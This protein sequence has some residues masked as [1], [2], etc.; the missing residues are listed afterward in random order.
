MDNPAATVLTGN[1]PDDKATG[2]CVRALAQS[3]ATTALEMKKYA[4]RRLI[5]QLLEEVNDYSLMRR[6]QPGVNVARPRAD[7]GTEQSSPVEE[8]W[9]VD[10]EIILSFAHQ[11]NLVGS[12]C[13]SP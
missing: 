3:I 7:T 12:S 4:F 11:D 9:M 10:D 13:S 8:L 2:Q 5:E 6:Q 1:V